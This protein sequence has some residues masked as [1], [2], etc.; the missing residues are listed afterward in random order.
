MK[1]TN[2]ISFLWFIV[3]LLCISRISHAA[4]KQSCYKLWQLLNSQDYQRYHQQLQVLPQ[5]PHLLL[6][7]LMRLQLNMS[8]YFIPLIETSFIAKHLSV[9]KLFHPWQTHQDCF[10]MF[11]YFSR[12]VFDRLCQQLKNSE[13]QLKI[14]IPFLDNDNKMVKHLLITLSCKTGVAWLLKINEINVHKSYGFL[15]HSISFKVSDVFFSSK[16]LYFFAD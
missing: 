8:T 9:Y 6:L 7:L 13:S 11:H 14:K 4:T 16:F 5:G 3:N 10:I 2:F 1:F 15:M 12:Y